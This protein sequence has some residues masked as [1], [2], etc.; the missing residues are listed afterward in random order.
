M[1]NLI[2][3]NMEALFLATVVV[4]GATNYAAA[5]IPASHGHRAAPLVDGNLYTVTV[6][7][8]RPA[9]APK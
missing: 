1:K 3:K 2:L 8:K 4:A 7:A 5:M 9:A 6:V